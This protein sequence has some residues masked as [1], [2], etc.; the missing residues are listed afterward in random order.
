MTRS[1]LKSLI[2]EC[3][4]EIITEGSGPSPVRES[5]QKVQQARPQPAAPPKRHPALDSI[6]MG[7]RQE[8]PRRTVAPPIPKQNFNAITSDPVMASIF[9]DTASTTLV[10]QV[11]AESGRSNPRVDTGVD[12]GIFEGSSNWAALAFS[13]APHKNR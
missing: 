5:R 10:E 6:V 12:P 9:A 8:V 11:G 3:L 13:E 2:K 4:I 1:E 7:G